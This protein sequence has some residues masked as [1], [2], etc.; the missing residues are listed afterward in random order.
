MIYRISF[1]KIRLL[2]KIFFQIRFKKIT[3]QHLSY[4][5]KPKHQSK[6][7]IGTRGLCIV[8]VRFFPIVCCMCGATPK[9]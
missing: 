2:S 6:F 5:Q 4:F 9:T 8:Y 7:Y 3:C 1:L